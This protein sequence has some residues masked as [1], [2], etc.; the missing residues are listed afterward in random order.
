MDLKT[1]LRQEAQEAGLTRIGFAGIQPFTREE[2]IL[3]RRLQEGQ[4]TL[5]AAGDILLRT[6]P[7][8][9]LPGAKSIVCVGAC[10]R[11]PDEIP[12]DNRLARYAQVTDY[13]KVLFSTLQRLADL[14]QSRMPEAKHWI[15]VDTGPL[16]ERAAAQRAGLGFVGKNCSLID[17]ERGSYWV[18]GALI[19]TAPIP[20]DENIH[21]DYGSGCGD[22]SACLKACP[23]GAL[24]AP[25]V[26][27]VERCLSYITQ[28]RG[29]IDSVYRR[30][31]RE[32][33]W[34]CDRCQS[35]C[36]YN[37]A[38]K[39]CAP[40][41]WNPSRDCVML[42]EI[43]VILEWDASGYRKAMENT[44]L[45]WRGR[46]VLQRNALLVLGNRKNP[47]DGVK[48]A[49]MLSDSRP[50]IRGHAAWALGQN[51]H[52]DAARWL[53]AVKEYESDRQVRLEIQRALTSLER[54]DLNG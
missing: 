12:Q 30:Y 27:R 29:W 8:K 48:M 44:A 41:M 11:L 21:F 2:E 49:A 9:I 1:K 46:T 5:S 17:P 54:E 28:K 51:P 6:H 45:F 52:P 13:H 14:I 25:G 10:Y 4:I 26:V 35:V 42:P 32:D 24:E 39:G 3:T 40:S 19:T 18:L 20:P 33:L 38:V 36:P 16:L 37:A 50:V 31:I 15:N 22:C 34:G 53:K 23:T 47:E 43:E 7:E